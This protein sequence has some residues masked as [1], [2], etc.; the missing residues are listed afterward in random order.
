MNWAYDQID[1]GK[2]LDVNKKYLDELNPN[3]TNLERLVCAAYLQVS[4]AWNSNNHDLS[5]I[6]KE[7]KYNC[8]SS[9]IT[10]K[11]RTLLLAYE[12]MRCWHEWRDLGLVDSCSENESILYV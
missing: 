3:F 8:K 1:E 2:R 11:L 12:Y 7:M 4:E 9:V 10:W 5:T 6:T